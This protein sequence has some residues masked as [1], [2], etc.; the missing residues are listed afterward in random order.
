VGPVGFGN[1]DVGITID[2]GGQNPRGLECRADLQGSVPAIR[3][4]PDGA[5]RSCRP[6]D[7]AD[8]TKMVTRGPA[9]AVGAPCRGHR[10]PAGNS[11]LCYITPP[12]FISLPS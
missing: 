5:L 11:T 10:E 3:F 1:P 4:G 7:E 6:G 9:T 2:E 8:R 12:D